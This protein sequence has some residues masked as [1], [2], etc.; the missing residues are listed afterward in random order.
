MNQTGCFFSVGPAHCHE[1]TAPMSIY[2][3]I[4][5][6]NLNVLKMRARAPDEFPERD[7]RAWMQ[8]LGATRGSKMPRMLC[9]RGFYLWH[10]GQ[11]TH[12]CAQPT[13]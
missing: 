6:H 11:P 5:N 10:C 8:V 2:L 4:C 9:V 13:V 12:E 1:Q 7:W 3:F